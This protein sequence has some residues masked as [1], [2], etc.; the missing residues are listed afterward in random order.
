MRKEIRQISDDGKTIRVTVAD[1]RWYIKTAEDGTITEY[2][3]VTWI[4]DSYPKGI[5]YYKY[6]ADKGWD[7][8]QNEL[9]AAGNRGSKVHKGITSLLL[10]NSIR[11]DDK[12]QNDDGEDEDIT[13]E[14]WEAIMSFS[15]WHKEANPTM[16]A[17]ELTV[18]NEEY[19]YAGTADFICLIGDEKYLIDF[20]TGK[21]IWPS[22]E[23]QLSAYAHA[24]PADMRPD[25]LAILQV[26]YK[27]NKAGFKFTEIPDQFDL[28]LAARSI[29]QKEHGTEKIHVKDYPVTI[30]LS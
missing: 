1:E 6:L 13:L 10:G 26:G 21:E 20:K 14:E 8:A 24:L 25:K 12:L 28:F 29:W 9:H 18:F 5:G 22:Y 17:N 15:A 23:L 2:P 16:L 7:N 11:M 3:S 4:A 27:R 19:K 30:S